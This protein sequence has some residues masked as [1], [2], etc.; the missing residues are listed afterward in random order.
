[1]KGKSMFNNLLVLLTVAVAMAAC[2][3]T[4]DGEKSS[5]NVAA[6][7]GITFPLLSDNWLEGTVQLAVKNS[8]GCGKFANDIFPHAV[9]KDFTVA[10]ESN[11][12]IF[13]HISRS[14][15]VKQCEFVGMF[16]ATKGNEYYLNVDMK[17]ENCK[18]TLLEKSP[19]DEKR[20]INTFPAYLSQVDGVTVCENKSKLY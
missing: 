10:I 12:D 16:Y 18:I 3:N 19:K 17:V 6:A 9:D 20:K 5:A 15:T 11:N 4:H 13:F 14:D 1:M 8:R 2:A 7:N